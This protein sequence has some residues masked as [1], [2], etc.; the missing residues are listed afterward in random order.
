MISAG[1]RYP[2]KTMKRRRTATPLLAIALAATAA[3]CGGG[4]ADTATPVGV[5]VTD[6]NPPTSTGNGIEA[7]EPGATTDQDGGSGVLGRSDA[8]LVSAQLLHLYSPDQATPGPTIDVW[9]TDPADPA[10]LIKV[11]GPIAYGEVGTIEVVKGFAD[12]IIYLTPAGGQKPDP[13]GP[14]DA[15]KLGS[16]SVRLRVDGEAPF[17]ALYDGPGFAGDGP[18]GLQYQSHDLLRSADGTDTAWLLASASMPTSLEGT[19]TVLELDGT[20]L[21]F[22]RSNNSSRNAVGAGEHRLVLRDVSA[23]NCPDGPALAT[24]S[25]TADE[26]RLT[27]VYLVGEANDALTFGSV[28]IDNGS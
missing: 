25:F 27:I 7:G 9:G 4:D 5:V 17:L 3:A 16:A 23:A 1:A 18:A 22:D 8:V 14:N 12:P 26:G 6:P 15:N 19:S 21:D 13:F 11:G 2:A 28:S 20:C 10:D 24:G